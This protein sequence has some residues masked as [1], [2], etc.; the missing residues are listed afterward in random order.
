[1]HHHGGVEDHGTKAS[2]EWT[3]A[4]QEVCHRACRQHTQVCL[5]LIPE[6]LAVPAIEDSTAGMHRRRPVTDWIPPRARM[7]TR[8]KRTA[9]PCTAGCRCALTSARYA[10]SYELGRFVLCLVASL[11]QHEHRSTTAAAR[12]EP[13]LRFHR[14]PCWQ[15]ILCH[16]H[17]MRM[18]RCACTCPAATLM[19]K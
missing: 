5:C 12:T 17:H 11:T 19:S 4:E 15:Q 8:C 14:R 7:Q 16:M 13:F 3:V 9:P 1:M 18:G 6:L 10:L 2:H